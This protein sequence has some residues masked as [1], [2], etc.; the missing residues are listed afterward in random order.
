MTRNSES[1][2]GWRPRYLDGAELRRRREG[3]G[4][5]QAALAAKAG[6]KLPGHVSHWEADDYGCE[7]ETICRLADALGCHATDLMHTDG[8]A[9]YKALTEALT[10]RTA[11]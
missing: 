8:K 1:R 7:I 11:A 3:A 10:G 9:K 4:L 6:V 2:K 5:T